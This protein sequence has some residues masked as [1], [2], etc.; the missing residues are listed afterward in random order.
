MM[1]ARSLPFHRLLLLGPLLP[2]GGGGVSGPALLVP[3]YGSK[4][5]L[6]TD[7]LF[8]R[9]SLPCPFLRIVRTT[10]GMGGRGIPILT[11]T[12]GIWQSVWPVS[13]SSTRIVYSDL[14]GYQTSDIRL[15]WTITPNPPTPTPMWL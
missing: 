5:R 14:V 15:L 11:T 2:L 4:H 3:L 13:L 12:G 6:A 10:R 8:P 1:I 7:P 9:T